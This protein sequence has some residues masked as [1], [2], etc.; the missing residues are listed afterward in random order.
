MDVTASVQPLHGFLD[1]QRKTKV[2]ATVAAHRASKM[3]LHKPVQVGR[4]ARLF[5]PPVAQFL[6]SSLLDPIRLRQHANHHTAR[7]AENTSLIVNSVA[8]LVELAAFKSHM[9]IGIRRSC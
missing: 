5:L 2:V 7:T 4:S 1:A 6:D 8:H 3:D 9:R